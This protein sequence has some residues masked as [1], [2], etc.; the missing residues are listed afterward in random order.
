VI[1]TDGTFNVL[2]AAEGGKIDLWMLTE[3]AFDRSRFSRR[4]RE[5]ALGFDFHVSSPENTFLAKLR[6]P[7]LAGESAKTYLDALRVYE[8]QKGVLDQLYLEDWANKLGVADLWELLQREA[9]PI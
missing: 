3:D 5:H 1:R 8:V 6:W 4:I 7:L 9:E 2:D